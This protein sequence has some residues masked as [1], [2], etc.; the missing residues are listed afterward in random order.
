M[1]YIILLAMLGVSVGPEQTYRVPTEVTWGAIQE[2][3]TGI[4]IET[5]PDGQLGARL[6]G[7]GDALVER[8]APPA[9]GVFVE[10]PGATPER[11][12]L[13]SGQFSM[14]SLKRTVGRQD[15]TSYLVG[16]SR[17]ER[18]GKVTESLSW[19][20]AY[21]AEGR[22]RLPGCEVNVAVLD[23]NGDGVFDRKDSLRG[24]TIGLDVNNDGRVWGGAEWRMAGEV[25]EVCGR[26][27]EVADIDPTGLSI[28]FRD[29]ALTP[30][31]VGSDLPSFG[32]VSTDGSIIRSSY[33]RGRVLLLDFWAT[34]CAPCVGSLPHVDALAREYS[35]NLAVVG[36]N[37]DEADRRASAEKVI[38]EKGLSFPQVIRSMGENDFLWKIF[39]SMKDMRQGIPLYVVVDGKGVIRY[40][41]Q[42]GNDLTDVKKLLEELAKQK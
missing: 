36:I 10:I 33:F 34:W 14:V 23:L 28:T 31:V 38:A 35:K 24:T 17:R 12:T 39:G 11:V 26:P 27:L 18:D 9:T 4:A 25:I 30:A 5:R 7:G 8:M 1:T 2:V 19:S 6:P 16:Y 3:F 42:G 37:V 22:L 29:S 41:G 13:L 15:R 21:R 20:P 32:V 40:A